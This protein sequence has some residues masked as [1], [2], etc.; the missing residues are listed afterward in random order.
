M[1]L[2]FVSDDD[3]RRFLRERAPQVV[4]P[5]PILTSSGQEIG[6]HQGLAFYTIGQRR[7]LGIAAREA[8]YVLRLDTEQNALVVGPARELGRSTLLARAVNYPSGRP[9]ASSVHVQARIRYRA[10]LADATWTPLPGGQA[11]VDFT[12][13][14][15]DITP[16]Q[17]VVAYQDDVVLAGG[18]ISE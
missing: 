14:L 12:A 8:L 13:P 2:C 10:T 11:Q 4:K 5:G 3:Y 6:R 16:G 18:I 9:P 7:G 17:A 1:E 15:R